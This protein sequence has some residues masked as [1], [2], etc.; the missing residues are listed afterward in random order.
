VDGHGGALTYDGSSWSDAV[1]IDPYG[2]ASVSCPSA[3]FC[4]AVEGLGLLTY[5]GSAWSAPE[6][7]DAGAGLS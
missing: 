1:R 5:D 4:A 6:N 2:L 3:G 7:I